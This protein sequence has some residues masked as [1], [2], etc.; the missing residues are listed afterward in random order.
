M[1][2]T[3]DANASETAAIDMLDIG[4]FARG[5]P[6]DAYARLRREAPVYRHAGSAI[7]PPFWVLSRYDDIKAVSQDGE[8]FTSTQGF[9]VST[10]NRARMDPE[11]ARTLSRFMLAMDNPEHLA[12]RNIV[13]NA[14]MPSA[15][16]ALEPRIARS[17]DNL[18]ERLEGRDVVEFVA[19]VGAM[20]P[21]QTICAVLGLPEEEEQ[22][23]FDF[24]NAVFMTDDPEFAPT[25]EV[26]NARYLE[27][28]DYAADV[29]A[30]RRANPRDDLLTRIA[31]AE[32]EGRPLDST[33]QKSFFSNLLAAG[34]ETTRTTLTGSIIA[35]SR[36]PDQKKAL[37]EDR[38]KIAS[39]VPEFLRWVSPVYHMARTAKSDTEIRGHRI[40]A[41][42][43]VA[44]L[45]GA[46]NY[47]PEVFPEPKGLDFARAN[48]AHHIT[49][50]WGIHHCL[51]SRLAM[52]Q[53]RLML[54][55]LLKRFPAIELAGE[56]V[57]IPSNFVGAF[58][59]VDV[60]LR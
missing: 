56:P 22:R 39:A 55:A 15:I 35:L 40:E 21:I 42:E 20:V 2:A 59:Q 45:Y 57:Y 54:D 29:F 12:F 33:E 60:R 1:T 30:D 46:A 32:V 5:H 27:I 17:I 16:K 49:F 19:E 6:H 41:G 7:Q 44:M 50:G 47:D 3:M 23:V 34:N 38:S 37:V 58:K 18:M 25:L 26:A 8:N 53:L 13:A 51:G 24:T 28:F 10:D 14:F 48:A 4:T 52:L 31:F 43:R 36:F 9:K 11:I